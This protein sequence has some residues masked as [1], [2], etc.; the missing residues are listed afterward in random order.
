MPTCTS[1]G[2]N[3]EYNFC[4]ICGSQVRHTFIEKEIPFF[5]KLKDR[6]ITDNMRDLITIVDKNGYLIYNSPSHLSVLGYLPTKKGSFLNFDAIHPDDLEHVYST[7]QQVV[8]LKQDFTAEFR[9]KKADGSYLWLEAKGTP[10]LEN[11]E[12]DY[13]VI[14]SRDIQARKE[15]EH[16][17]RQS[18]LKYRLI[19]SHTHD[20]I[21]VLTAEGLYE[22]AS[23]SYIQTLGIDP[24]KLI[25]KHAL[26]QI[27]PDDAE[28]TNEIL[29]TMVQT[30]QP[31]TFQYRKTL[32]NGSL[33]L[34][35]GRGVPIINEETNHVEGF[36]FVSRDITEQ[37]KL[38]KIMINSEKL[39]VI[40]Q[41]AAS[42]AHEIRNPL[43]TIKGFIQLFSEKYTSKKDTA[44]KEMIQ[45]EL[46][47]I[48]QIVNEF[49]SLAKQEA[50]KY[51]Q[52][53]INSLLEDVF[54]RFQHIFINK[55]II[56]NKEYKEHCSFMIEGQSHQLKQ[57]FIHVVQNA[58]DSMPFGGNLFASIQQ[59][60]SSHLQIVFKDSGFG[61][62]HERI[63]NIGQPFYTT[64]ERGVG[65]GLTIC[66]KVIHEH[67]GSFTLSSVV[68]E[69]TTVEVILPFKQTNT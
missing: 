23:P 31:K 34:L 33:L 6:I 52:V 48:E 45:N 36:V 44:Y 15:A 56:L 47:Q 68:N 35:E 1:C 7:F 67:S 22:Y 17:L 4:R 46:A 53:H 21:C 37:R 40:G 8:S 38:E 11:Q 49:M 62:D 60:D 10:I 42:I 63:K 25:G 12:I 18:E 26:Y 59:Y 55:D 57:V 69:G 39:S 5:N 64:K 65:L 29:K 58:I 30:K 2:Y 32:A 41:L 43:T 27:H 50:K 54:H 16:N 24:S 28:L 66:N 51:E 14:T 3:E 19:L 13:I 61:I 20:L 9:Y